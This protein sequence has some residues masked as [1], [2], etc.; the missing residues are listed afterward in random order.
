MESL[1]LNINQAEHLMKL[2]LDMSDAK[3]YIRANYPLKSNVTLIVNKSEYDAY[4][5]VDRV[6]GPEFKYVP[7]YTLQEILGK[8][9]DEIKINKKT[10][11]LHIDKNLIDYT[12]DEYD[13]WET[14]FSTSE[15]NMLD[16]AYEAL[17]WVIKNGHLKTK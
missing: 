8:L 5:K 14:E 16:M 2:K 1:W 4:K 12:Y 17:S 15:G 7:T 13:Y 11:R 10:Y 9:P 6:L 3:C